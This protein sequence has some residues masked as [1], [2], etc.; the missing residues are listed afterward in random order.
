MLVLALIL[1]PAL[2]RAVPRFQP[3]ELREPTKNADLGT[4]MVGTLWCGKG[5]LLWHHN[6]VDGK[7]IM[8]TNAKSFGELS[9]A[10]P[11][12]DSCCRLHDYCPWWAAEGDTHAR[13]SSDAHVKA[14]RDL[15]D[16]TLRF[17]LEDSRWEDVAKPFFAEGGGLPGFVE[18]EQCGPIKEI[19]GK[20]EVFSSGCECDT[21]FLQCV[22]G[23]ATMPGEEESAGFIREVYFHTAI[24][25]ALP[26]GPLSRLLTTNVDRNC[27][28]PTAGTRRDM[29][30]IRDLR[31]DR[32]ECTCSGP[33]GAGAGEDKAWCYTADGCG[34]PAMLGHWDFCDKFCFDLRLRLPRLPRRIVYLRKDWSLLR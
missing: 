11:H 15:R 4:L 33:C 23:A 17:D 1:P 10:A 22:N 14:W 19:A 28:G 30:F 3:N 13:C 29:T 24:S 6:V 20:D 27:I 2:A 12:L 21:A 18:Y 16:Q 7:E 32:F 5:H 8:G 34:A 25:V 31:T 9:T 26:V